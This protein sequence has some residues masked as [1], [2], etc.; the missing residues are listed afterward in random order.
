MK[1]NNSIHEITKIGSFHENHCEDYTVC[2]AIGEDRLLLA[3]LDGCTMGEE[4]YFASALIG[5]LA[6]KIGKEEFYKEYAEK[7]T[8]A[9]DI[10]LKAIYRQL[11][12]GL[13]EMKNTLM[14][15]R[16]ELLSTIVLGVV[17]Q[18]EKEAELLVVG[19]GVISCNGNLTEFDQE[20]V[21][22]YI[23]YHLSEDFDEWYDQ[24]SQFVSLKDVHDLSISTDGIFTFSKYDT[25]T[26]PE[27]TEQELIDFLLNDNSDITNERMY[28][29]KLHHLEKNWGLLPTDDLGIVRVINE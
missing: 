12:D 23:G 14:L 18:H 7:K 28:V 13:K 5:K 11:F 25:E 15:E 26:Y 19:D 3:V 21:P 29:K 16:G 10:Q 22:D 24:Q 17:D 1:K 8:A 4:S 20:N 2:T 6:K 27:R 9:L